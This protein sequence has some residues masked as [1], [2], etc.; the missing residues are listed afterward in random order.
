MLLLTQEFTLNVRNLDNKIKQNFA[1]KAGIILITYI[2]YACTC[3][4]THVDIWYSYMQRSKLK[5]NLCDWKSIKENKSRVIGDFVRAHFSEANNPTP[6][7]KSTFRK[8]PQ[9]WWH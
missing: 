5:G 7:Y 4:H 9:S 1:K 8:S 2:L 3:V 6:S